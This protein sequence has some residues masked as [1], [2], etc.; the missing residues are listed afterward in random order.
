MDD[1]TGQKRSVRVARAG[2]VQR[3]ALFT[4]GL[5]ALVP[6]TPLSYTIYP[7]TYSKVVRLHAAVYH[8]NT[9]KLAKLKESPIGMDPP[10]PTKFPMSPGMPLFPV[11]PERAAGTRP[12][13][14]APTAQSPSL[15]D[16]RLSP[17][18]KHRRNDSDISVQG[19]AAMFEHLEVKD[20]KEAQA[21]YTRALEKQKDAHEKDIQALSRKHQQDIMRHE[22][23]VEE[24]RHAEK[25]LRELRAEHEGCPSKK[26]WD[27]AR[28]QQREADAQWMQKVKE[29]EEY[30]KVMEAKLVSHTTR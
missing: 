29:I 5:P 11:S 19:L 12:P 10:S 30:K 14:G 21:K 28:Q 7:T 15:P 24:L 25:E 1:G 27:A 26:K 20:F 9:V 3:L 8:D 6:H 23:R 13:Y 4:P 18:R 17:L 16:L 2:K 22:L